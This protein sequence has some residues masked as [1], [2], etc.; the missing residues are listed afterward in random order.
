MNTTREKFIELL[1][2]NEFEKIDLN[3]DE[4]KKLI[5]ENYPCISESDINIIMELFDE[6]DKFTFGEQ[7]I[8]TG[9]ISEFIA[10]HYEDCVSDKI[11]EYFEDADCNCIF[12]DCDV[13]DE[14]TFVMERIIICKDI[15]LINGYSTYGDD[16]S[17]VL[18]KKY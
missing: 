13:D 16:C 8:C 1:K 6:N 7:A 4:A 9:D 2:N 18:Y 15:I 11:Y 10:D 5:A 12:T 17:F 3:V 14:P